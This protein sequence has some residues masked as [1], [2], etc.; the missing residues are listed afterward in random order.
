M[1]CITLKMFCDQLGY[2][3]NDKEKSLGLFA[4]MVGVSISYVSK[5]YN[6]KPVSNGGPAWDKLCSFVEAYGYQLVNANPTDF[7]NNNIIK[8]NKK[9]KARIEYLENYVKLLELQVNEVQELIRVSKRI[10]DY[11]NDRR[12]IVCKK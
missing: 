4:K 12:T 11:D 1:K 6:A 2:K 10:A 9:L 7:M 5:V 3:P 8:E